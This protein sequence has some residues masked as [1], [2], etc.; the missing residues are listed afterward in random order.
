MYRNRKKFVFTSSARTISSTESSVK[1]ICKKFAC[2][3]FAIYLFFH[4]EWNNLSNIHLEILRQIHEFLRELRKM[5]LVKNFELDSF[6]LGN[7]LRFAS[8]SVK[9]F[10]VVDLNFLRLR[11]LWWIYYSFFFFFFKTVWNVHTIFSNLMSRTNATLASTRCYSTTA[12]K[13]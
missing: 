1:K 9:S 3:K 11:Y 8:C 12:N 5:Q 2:K 4:K 13:Q 7:L 10:E 6:D